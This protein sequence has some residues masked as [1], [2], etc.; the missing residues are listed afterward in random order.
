MTG[1][2]LDDTRECLSLPDAIS[3]YRCRIQFK[4]RPAQKADIAILVWITAGYSVQES[5]N[6]AAAVRA[7]PTK[8]AVSVS[9]KKIWPMK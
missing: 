4:M 6:G 1:G 2:S 9:A 8:T 7:S 5:S 3:V